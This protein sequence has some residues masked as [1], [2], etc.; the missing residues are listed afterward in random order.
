MAL[1]T[2]NQVREAAVVRARSEILLESQVIYEEARALRVY[3]Q[4]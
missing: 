2:R 3:I 1:S 4:V